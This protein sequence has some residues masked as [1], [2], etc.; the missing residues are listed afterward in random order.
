MAVLK[1]GAM[2]VVGKGLE[3]DASHTPSGDVKLCHCFV[4]I[5]WKGLKMDITTTG[6]RNAISGYNQKLVLIKRIHKYQRYF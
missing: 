3:S 2:S 1:E 4:N 6:A 5:V